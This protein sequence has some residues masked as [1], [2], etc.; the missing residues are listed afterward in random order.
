MFVGDSL[1]PYRTGEYL[2]SDQSD[3]RIVVFGHQYCTLWIIH[4]VHNSGDKH[5]GIG[6][7]P[8]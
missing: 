6:V 2:D 7:D 3:N 4:P 5:I 1:T 8:H